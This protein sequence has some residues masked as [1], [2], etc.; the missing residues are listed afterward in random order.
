MHTFY[1]DISDH[2]ITSVFDS[3]LSQYFH[4][5]SLNVSWTSCTVRELPIAQCSH[6]AAIIWAFQNSV[7]ASQRIPNLKYLSYRLWERNS[8]N[9]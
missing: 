7:L 9:H 2:L 6:N 5:V 8:Q 3:H 1:D 4:L